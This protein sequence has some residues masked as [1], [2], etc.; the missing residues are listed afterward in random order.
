MGQIFHNKKT[1]KRF[2]RQE[3]FGGAHPLSLLPKAIT[4]SRSH[5]LFRK[6]VIGGLHHHLFRKNVLL[7]AD[8]FWDVKGKLIVNAH[9]FGF[10]SFGGCVYP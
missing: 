10:S 4:L 7:S 5:Q 2:Y 1:S 8:P 6:A 3:V 9:E